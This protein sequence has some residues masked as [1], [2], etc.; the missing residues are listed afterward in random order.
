MLEALL[1]STALTPVPPTLPAAEVA[2]PMALVTPLLLLSQKP[3]FTVAVSAAPRKPP[4]KL[5]AVP[6]KLCSTLPVA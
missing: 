6:V 3:L 5:A 4:T 1:L 2:L